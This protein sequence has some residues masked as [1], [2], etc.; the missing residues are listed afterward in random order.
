MWGLDI[1]MTNLP[2]EPNP[3]DLEHLAERLDTLFTTVPRSDDSSQFHTSASVAEEL[4]KQGIEVTPNHIRALRTGRRNNP[5]F[6]LLVGLAELFH[7]PIDY[8]VDDSVAKEIQESLDALVAIRGT[9]VQQIMLR[10][11]G[12]SSESL[13]SV[14]NLLD[15]IRR[16]EGLEGQTGQGS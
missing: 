3:N 4:S 8:F 11:H 14:L 6:R 15:Q 10:A 16:I 1:P 9:A 13:D 12:V 5:S 2:S 7:V